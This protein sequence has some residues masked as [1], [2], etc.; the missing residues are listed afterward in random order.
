MTDSSVFRV[1]RR[2]VR[3]GCERAYEE[4]IQAM[5]AD[6]KKFPGYLAAEMIP[7][8]QAG[9]DYQIIQRFA[10]EADLD[11]WNASSER[12]AWHER[13]HP[14][15]EGD[16]EYRLLHGLDAWFAPTAVPAHK[17]PPRW[18]MTVVSWM[19]I[20]P[21]VAFLLAFVGPLLAPF[22]FLLRTALLT[23]L[24][25]GLMSYVIMPRLTRWMG[26]WLRR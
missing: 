18:R 5:F 20:F 24:V 8:A 1:V 10:T 4:L 12:A 25:A 9:D 26:W 3:P 15:A 19:G 23:A 13:L 22:P 2:R 21:T 6:A 14:V 7:P 16:P 11:R 17:P